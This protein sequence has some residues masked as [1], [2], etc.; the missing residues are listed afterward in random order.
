MH[1]CVC[2][3][4]RLSVCPT[5]DLG[6]G[7][8]YC[9]ASFASVKSFSW[10]VAQAAFQAY[11]THGSRGKVFGTFCQVTRWRPCMHVTLP[12]TRVSMNLAHHLNAIGT[13]SKVTRW[14]ARPP[15]HGYHS[16]Y[17]FLRE[18]VMDICKVW[19]VDWTVREV[20]YTI[21]NQSVHE[22]VTTG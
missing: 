13:F 21:K 1:V 19:T 15:H 22:R 14:R 11:M 4:V 3:P 20:D 18:R 16:W 10:R 5:R 6:N 2:L 17:C 9:P 8:L 12:V 7:T